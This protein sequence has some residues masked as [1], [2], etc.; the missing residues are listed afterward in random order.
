MFLPLSMVKFRGIN[1]SRPLHVIGFK[2]IRNAVTDLK[3]YARIRNAVRVS[4]LKVSYLSVKYRPLMFEG[5]QKGVCTP[6][7]SMFGTSQATWVREV[8]DNRAKFEKPLPVV[9]RKKPCL[10]IASL[11]IIVYLTS[12]VLPRTGHEGPEGK[13][14]YSSTLP[15]TST[16][17]GGGW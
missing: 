9:I 15:S 1:T 3:L 11:C 12:K 5:N 2:N 16:L 4:A 10:L 8:S 6:I 17:D 14:M 13:Q 7:L